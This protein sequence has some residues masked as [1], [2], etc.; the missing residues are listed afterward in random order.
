MAFEVPIKLVH[1]YLKSL[2]R[3]GSLKIVS[4]QSNVEASSLIDGM[5]EIQTELSLECM[6]LVMKTACGL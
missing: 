3:R 1:Q 6:G 4:C 5:E 2:T